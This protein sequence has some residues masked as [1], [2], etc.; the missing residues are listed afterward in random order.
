MLKLGEKRIE[1]ERLGTLF[2]GNETIQALQRLVSCLA[3][4]TVRSFTC[5]K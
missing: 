4:Y 2:A 3:V 1:S 5:R